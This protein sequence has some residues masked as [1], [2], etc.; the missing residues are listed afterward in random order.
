MKKLI[1][2]VIL[3]I[4][5]YVLYERYESSPAPEALEG[6]NLSLLTSQLFS[7]LSQP[8][9][10]LDQHMTSMRVALRTAEEHGTLATE[11]LAAGNQLYQALTGIRRE[12]ALRTESLARIKEGRVPVLNGTSEEE[13]RA[14]FIGDLEQRWETYTAQALP[15]INRLMDRLTG[16]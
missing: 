16:N 13:R 2:I 1:F 8:Q 9:P 7:P 6:V 12:R 10:E 11:Q 3:L 4:L 5:G 14:F 15:R